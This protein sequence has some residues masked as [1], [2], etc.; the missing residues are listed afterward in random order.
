[1]KRY[2]LAIVVLA[3][4]L[5]PNFASADGRFRGGGG[6]SRGGYGHFGGGRGFYGGGHYGG[7]SSFGFSFG[8]FGGGY[9]RYYDSYYYRPVYRSY[10]YYAPP[11]A[12]YYD[13]PVYYAPAPR[14]YDRYDDCDYYYR[15]STSFSFSYGRYYR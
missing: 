2:L 14:R 11:P 8:L 6:Y 13:D 9:P 4:T 15:P 1:M 12:Y 5:I 7:R 10:T 3:V